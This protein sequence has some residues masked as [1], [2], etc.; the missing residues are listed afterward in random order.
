LCVLLSFC[1]EWLYTKVV[2]LSRNRTHAADQPQRAL[3]THPSIGGDDDPYSRNGNSADGADGADGANVGSDGGK[4][5]ANG[6]ANDSTQRAEKAVAAMNEASAAHKAVCASKGAK[7]TACVAAR[8][9]VLLAQ[10]VVVEVIQSF[11]NR[12]PK[13]PST[14]NKPQSAEPT[15]RKSAGGDSPGQSSSADGPMSRA[16]GSAA[17]TASGVDLDRFSCLPQ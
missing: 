1:R 3:K 7:S 10:E 9:A 6:A 17:N 8:A 2:E 16:I 12:S 11:E 14:G 5:A 15:D 13:P 4:A